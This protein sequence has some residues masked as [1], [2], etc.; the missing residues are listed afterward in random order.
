MAERSQNSWYRDQDR[1]IQRIGARTSRPY[2][3]VPHGHVLY[4]PLRDGCHKLLHQYS[5]D[6]YTFLCSCARLAYFICIQFSFSII[7]NIFCSCI[8]LWFMHSIVYLLT[9]LKG[10][11]VRYKNI[12]QVLNSNT[13]YKGVQKSSALIIK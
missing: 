12:N 7:Y 6:N 2:I 8:L 1:K 4:L 10:A 11:K 13:K 5:I 9:T 3:M